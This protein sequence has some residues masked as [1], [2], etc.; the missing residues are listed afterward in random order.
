MNIALATQERPVFDE[1][2][3]RVDDADL[4]HRDFTLDE[5]FANS[6]IDDPQEFNFELMYLDDAALAAFGFEPEAGVSDGSQLT[7]STDHSS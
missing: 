6:Y 2:M 4:Y 5:T 3:A 1:A 7:S